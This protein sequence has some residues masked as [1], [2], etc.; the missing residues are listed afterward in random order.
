MT[1]TIIPGEIYEYL[2]P[3]WSWKT[4]QGEKI[5]KCECKKCGGTCYIKEQAIMEHVVTNCGCTTEN[6][7]DWHYI[8][9]TNITSIS[10]IYHLRRK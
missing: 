3:R 6:G 7:I 8:P 2:V 4:N 1:K 5:W 9:K 10:N